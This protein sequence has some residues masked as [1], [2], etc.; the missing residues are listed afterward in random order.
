M[1]DFIVPAN[2]AF[3]A[4]RIVAVLNLGFA[5]MLAV[6]L[7]LSLICCGAEWLGDRR[8]RRHRTSLRFLV[9]A[10][11]LLSGPT[12]VRAQLEQDVP[13]IEPTFRRS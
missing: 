3:E 12:A 1:S 13:V 8:H 10:A 6:I 4:L 9:L 11:V 7:L 5:A 2:L